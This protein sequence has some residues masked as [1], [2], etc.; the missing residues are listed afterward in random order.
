VE[1]LEVPVMEYKDLMVGCL[2]L[3]ILPQVGVAVVELVMQVDL[4]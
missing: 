2:L 4:F 1:E 3:L